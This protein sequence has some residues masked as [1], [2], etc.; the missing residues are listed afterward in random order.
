MREIVIEFVIQI[1]IEISMEQTGYFNNV[2]CS[3]T[4]IAWPVSL[5]KSWLIF[6][7]EQ[8]SFWKLLTEMTKINRRTM[9]ARPYFNVP[10]S[11]VLK[12]R[13]S[14]SH[15]A[16]VEQRVP[17]S[18]TIS[19]TVEHPTTTADNIELPSRSFQLH[20]I[21]LNGVSRSIVRTSF[22]HSV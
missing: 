10:R 12:N 8:C 2:P 16:I 21:F 22:R 3:A 13:Q 14:P 9:T 6:Q 19:S 20:L 11:T 18:I 7:M 15:I 4:S 17:I 5:L 1:V